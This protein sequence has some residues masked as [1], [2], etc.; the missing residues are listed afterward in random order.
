MK[1]KKNVSSPFK[2][3]DFV[4]SIKNVKRYF[5]RILEAEFV[6]KAQKRKINGK[7]MVIYD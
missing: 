7:F 4:S 3:V 5:Q 6:R 2:K 1:L